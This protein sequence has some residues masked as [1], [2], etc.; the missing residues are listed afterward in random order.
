MIQASIIIRF[1]GAEIRGLYLQKG[2]YPQ[3]TE[4]YQFIMQGVMREF[5]SLKEA[6][7]YWRD[8]H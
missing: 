6:I 1:D 4:H 8:T 5:N 2:N 7:D 3:L